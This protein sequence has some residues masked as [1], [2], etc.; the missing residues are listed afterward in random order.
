MQFKYLVL[1]LFLVISSSSF[2]RTIFQG[3]AI[4]GALL[5]G[6][7]EAG[8][9]VTVNGRAVR[10]SDKGDFI[11]GFGRDYAAKAT[12][13]IE[14]AS[15]AKETRVFKV[16]RRDYKVQKINGLPPSKVTPRSAKT[17]ARI[18]REGAAISKARRKDDARTDFLTDWIWPTKGPISGVYG[19]QRILN[20]HKRRPHFG[21]DVAAPTG[22]AVVAPTDGIIT[23][24]N[25]DMF[26]SGGTLVLDH[27]HRLSSSFLHL[28]KILVKVGDQVKQGDII[29]EV[30]A[31]GRVT[32]AHLDWRMNYHKERT[33]PAF[34]V[35]P[36]DV[37]K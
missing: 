36:M 31:T 18:K 21:V 37:S 29:A 10:V 9:K 15:K 32:G 28:S 7:T 30:G 8:A 35:P 1:C 14:Y 5:F 22:T 17:L 23:Y 16:K 26:F 2:A 24:A 12:V 6:K 25:K 34:L 20:G 11:V 33:D 19:S 27:G 4:Q 13:I 3:E